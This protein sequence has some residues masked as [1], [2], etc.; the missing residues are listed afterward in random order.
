MSAPPPVTLLGPQRRPGLDRVVESLGLTGPFATI[1]SGWQERERDDAELSAH[2]A[3]QSVNL[4]LWHRLQDVLEKDPAYAVADNDRRTM[5][6]EMQELY[7]LGVGHAMEALLSL[8]ERPSATESLVARAV[9]DAEDVLRDLDARHLRRVAAV[10]AAFYDAVAPHDRPVI[11]A[12]RAEVAALQESSS[13]VVLT[14]GHVGV[15]LDTLHLFNV[16]PVLATRPVIAWS[17]GAMV[18]TDRV[19]LFNDRATHGPAFPEVYDAG[20]GLVPGVV[21]LPAAHQRLA[22]SSRPRTASLS[23]RFAPARC[24]PLDPGARVALGADRSLPASASVISS[25]GAVMQLG[26]VDDD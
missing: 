5:L 11:A 25:S 8:Y 15:L 13:A 16:A 19:V 17:A 3:D 10:H 18:L 23:K 4:G 7:L 22:L 14:G 2:L 21:A 26:E 6:G 1:T 9:A 20:L 24:L 12:H